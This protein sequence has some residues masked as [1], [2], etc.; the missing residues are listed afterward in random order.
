MGNILKRKGFLL[1]YD[2]LEKIRKEVVIILKS[3]HQDKFECSGEFVYSPGEFVQSPSSNSH[4]FSQYPIH[5]NK[6]KVPPQPFPHTTIPSHPNSST[7][8]IYIP[9]ISIMYY[10]FSIGEYLVI[11]F[12][13]VQFLFFV[14]MIFPLISIQYF[15]QSALQQ[16]PML[17][18][19]LFTHPPFILLHTSL[20]L[21]RIQTPV[22]H[23][24]S[25][26]L[27]RPRREVRVARDLAYKEKH[28]LLHLGRGEFLP[29]SVF[30]YCYSFLY[31]T[32]PYLPLH[33]TSSK[34]N[35]LI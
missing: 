12:V 8:F 7:Q 32:N 24:T 33:D 25:T 26:P 35:V 27:I 22:K 1:H 29:S 4:T 34:S 3:L 2:R 15:Q 14:F 9:Y 5:K 31:S 16:S 10:V 19:C 17:S 21:C 20:K 30:L 18:Q 23:Y 28:L 11:I 6:I 13:T